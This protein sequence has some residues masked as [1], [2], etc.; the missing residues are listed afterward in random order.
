MFENISLIKQLFFQSKTYAFILIIVSILSIFLEGISYA[1]ILP[2]LENYLSSEKS[3]N[4]SRIISSLF[5]NVGFTISTLSI[6]IVFVIL[7]LFKNFFRILREYL[8]ANYKYYLREIWLDNIYKSLDKSDYEKITLVN[9]GKLYNNVYHETN[10]STQGMENLIEI[11]TSFISLL[12]FI[13]ILLLTSIQFTLLIAAISIFIFLLNR[14]LLYNYSKKVGNKEVEL[15]QLVSSVINDSLVSIKNIKAF[16]VMPDFSMYINNHIKN[17]RK[18]IVQW[19]VYT[20]STMPVIE[21]FLVFTL[22]AFILYWNSSNDNLITL[23]PLLAVIV[24]VG[25]R[26]MQQLSR[27]L[28]A[29]NSFNRMKKSFFVINELMNFDKSNKNFKTLNIEKSLILNELN[30]NI[31]ISNVSF[32]YEKSNANNKLLDNLNLSIRKG[33]ITILKGKSGSGKSTF[34]DLL[35]GLLVPDTG[36]ININDN[37][38]YNYKNLNDKIVTVSQKN[39]L[40][41]DTIKSNI[42][43]FNKINDEEYF[44]K[45]TAK[46][47][48][49]NFVN[50][51]E[52]KYET[53]IE[54]SG[55][56][57]SG[58]QT[59]RICIARALIRK[60]EIL[61]LDEVTSS[62]DEKNEKD[63]FASI[64][65]LM[66]GKTVIISIHKNII[67]EYADDIYNIDNGKFIKI[68]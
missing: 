1:T 52:N 41:T 24:V 10:N 65:E 4:L 45:I 67:D 50:N 16:K 49:D 58:G 38:L 28:I 12:F 15:N 55:E 59:Q 18:I 30:K 31:E 17:L 68:K 62:L 44:K 57:L 27:F 26:L 43:F 39:I 37:E 21:T 60:P 63:I 23:I 13:I 33:K 48:I 7:I 11:F 6:S 9:R 46:L 35:S 47:N 51:F 14:L 64:L 3:S 42:L 29:I 34:L 8:T 54:N 32:N 2:L 22:I 25:Q 5:N 53:I 40:I 20:F 56:N 19:R 66:K 61:I 36:S